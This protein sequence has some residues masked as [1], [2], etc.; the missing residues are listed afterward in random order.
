MN[1]IVQLILANIYTKVKTR[2]LDV[3]ISYVMYLD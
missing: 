3:Y 2:Y 1:Y